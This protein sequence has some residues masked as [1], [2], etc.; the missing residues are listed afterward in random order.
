MTDPYYIVSTD[1]LV[2][3]G[4]HNIHIECLVTKP[5]AVARLEELYNN[6]HVVLA[7]IQGRRL[8]TTKKTRTYYD[9]EG[10]VQ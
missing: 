4:E 7:V 10:Q 2:E 9:I 1:P 3:W 5:A 6:G 8:K